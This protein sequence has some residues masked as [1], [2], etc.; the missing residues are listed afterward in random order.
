MSQFLRARPLVSIQPTGTCCEAKSIH[1]ILLVEVLG[2]SIE[3]LPSC[4]NDVLSTTKRPFFGAYSRYSDYKFI[5][6]QNFRFLEFS[7]SGYAVSTK[8]HHWH[9]NTT[10]RVFM[11]ALRFTAVHGLSGNHMTMHRLCDRLYDGICL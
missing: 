4:Q 9:D 5:C 8:C 2:T 6:A 11:V 1:L 7:S 10:P 3:V